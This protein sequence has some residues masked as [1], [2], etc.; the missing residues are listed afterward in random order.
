[1]M[2][3]PESRELYCC[4]L[5]RGG[6]L[7]VFVSTIKEWTDCNEFGSVASVQ[8]LSNSITTQPLKAFVRNLMAGSKLL[9]A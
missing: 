5:S 6:D 2:E 4:L 9:Q 7:K 3:Q 1:M 8:G